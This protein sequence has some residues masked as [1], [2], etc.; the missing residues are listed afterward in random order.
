MQSKVKAFPREEFANPLSPNVFSNAVKKKLTEQAERKQHFTGHQ[1][2]EI[3][4]NCLQSAMKGIPLAPR[5]VLTV[6]DWTPYDAQLPKAV[7]E[8]IGNKSLPCSACV[9]S[10][11]WASKEKND[12]AKYVQKQTLNHIMAQIEADRLK[13]PG[14]P[15]PGTKPGASS[16]AVATTQLNHNLFLLSKPVGELSCSSPNGGLRL[17][18]VFL[19]HWGKFEHLA[20]PLNDLVR[21]HNKSFNPSGQSYRERKRTVDETLVAASEPD[22]D[23]VVLPSAGSKSDLK[24]QDIFIYVGSEPLYEVIVDKAN[25]G[26]YLHGLDDGIVP[27]AAFLGGFG[28]GSYESGKDAEKIIQQ[29]KGACLNAYLT[30]A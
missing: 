25:A 11:A 16:S 22:S 9:V 24:P 14:A 17:T 21:E 3:W 18:Q 26:L 12:I 15:P 1:E 8:L 13:C 28:D 10:V 19:D 20:G 30:T 7:V 2:G 23:A 4:Q 6:I 27:C 5:H 29:G